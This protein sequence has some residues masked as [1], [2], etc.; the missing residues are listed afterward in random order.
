MVMAFIRN[1]ALIICVAVFLLSA[2]S[3]NIFAQESANEE[4]T[5]PLQV[6]YISGDNETFLIRSAKENI[7]LS[8]KVK[9]TT[10]VVDETVFLKNRELVSYK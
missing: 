6:K 10:K 7:Q 8:H 2:S 3:I 5:S 4:N 9:V 1:K